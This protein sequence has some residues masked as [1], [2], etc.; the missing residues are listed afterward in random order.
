MQ[1][2]A[3]EWDSVLRWMLNFKIVRI[4]PSVRHKIEIYEKNIG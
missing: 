3:Q 1:F 2:Y 4:I